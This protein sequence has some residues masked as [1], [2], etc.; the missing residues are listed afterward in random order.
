MHE[1]SLAMHLVDLAL[2]HAAKFP[3]CKV[4]RA[5][6][7]IGHWACVHPPSLQ[8]SV[9]MASEG[10]AMEGAEVTFEH[11]EGRELELAWIELTEQDAQP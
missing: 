2:E 4:Q 3:G 7:R 5:H 10:T 11:F 8:S 9:A 6:V 1:L